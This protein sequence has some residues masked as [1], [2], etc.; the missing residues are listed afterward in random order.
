[1]EPKSVRC[2][3]NSEWVD[4]IKNTKYNIIKSWQQNSADGHKQIGETKSVQK[5]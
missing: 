2:G 3:R 5:Q 4:F 1:M